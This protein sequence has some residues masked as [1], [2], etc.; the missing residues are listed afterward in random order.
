MFSH[1]FFYKSCICIRITILAQMAAGIIC[2]YVHPEQTRTLS[3]SLITFSLW[4]VEMGVKCCLKSIDCHASGAVCAI[5]RQLI[6][7]CTWPYRH[8]ISV[9]NP[10]K[11]FSY[12][13]P[14]SFGYFSGIREIPFN[15]F[16]DI[17]KADHTGFR[18]T[19]QILCHLFKFRD[20]PFRG[21]FLINEDRIISPAH[22]V[23]ANYAGQFLK[24]F[25]HL[26]FIRY[27]RF[28]LFSIWRDGYKPILA[29]CFKYIHIRQHW[30]RILCAKCNQVNHIRCQAISRYLNGVIWITDKHKAFLYSI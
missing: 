15:L 12:R 1:I 27:I 26:F 30:C 25:H 11:R 2:T 24:I 29:V 14:V 5:G 22:A 19:R 28:N 10:D 9:C 6:P 3:I 17:N 23:H 8:T 18:I 20:M 16:V 7:L 13:N 21:M 4:H